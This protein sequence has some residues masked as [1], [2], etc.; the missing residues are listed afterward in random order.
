MSDWR[1]A[2]ACAGMGV[3][4]RKAED[5]FFFIL[6]GRKSKRAKDFCKGCPVR[7]RCLE[8]ALIYDEYGIWGGTTEDE[9]KDYP[10]YLVEALRE[11]E[12]N[13]IGLES[14]N[15]EEFFTDRMRTSQV[16]RQVTVRVVEVQVDYQGHQGSLE[17][18]VEGQLEALALLLKQTNDLLESVH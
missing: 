2:A 4:F 9:R 1:G 3:T 15:F 11:R 18:L 8:Y 10:R 13:T 14:R 5:D 12:A 16:T 17:A 6:P 7:K